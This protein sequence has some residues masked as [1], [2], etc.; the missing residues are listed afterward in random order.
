MSKSDLAI[1]TVPASESNYTKGRKGY[2]ICKITPHH[3]AEVLTAEECGKIFQNPDRKASSNY[4]I[5]YDGKIAC[6]VAEED[7]AWTS[8]NEENDCQAI[9][10]EVS[11]SKMGDDWP[12]SDLAWNSLV[13]L[14]VDICKRYSFRLIYDGTPKGSLT[15][16]DMFKDTNCPG[17]YLNAKFD[18]LVQIVNSRLDSK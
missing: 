5:G 12:I 9:T 15:R 14:C 2:K 8:S 18:E 7:R 10:I 6:Y 17:P 4:G 1:I 11:N 13:R 16:H 3:M